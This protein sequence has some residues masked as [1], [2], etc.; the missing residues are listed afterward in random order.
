MTNIVMQSA[1]ARKTCVSIIINQVERINEVYFGSISCR[2][3]VVNLSDYGI[4]IEIS[5]IFRKEDNIQI[6][7]TEILLNLDFYSVKLHVVKTFV[8]EYKRNCFK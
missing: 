4:I 6:W 2:D 3:F 7:I 1:R 5:V 8:T